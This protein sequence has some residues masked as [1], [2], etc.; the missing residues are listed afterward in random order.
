[1]S[2]RADLFPMRQFYETS[3]A[4]AKSHHCYDIAV[5]A[6]PISLGQADARKSAVPHSMGVQTNQQTR[7]EI[8]TP[9]SA[10]TVNRKL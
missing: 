2:P 3:N 1:M 4:D 6:P 8:H 7:P 5:V 9:T 10:V